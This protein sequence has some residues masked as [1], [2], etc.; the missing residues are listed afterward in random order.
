M[1]KLY[2]ELAGVY[3]EMY[4][5]IFDYEKE[6]GLYDRILRR[7]HCRSVLEVGCGGGRLAPFFLDAGYRYQGIDVSA[8]MLRIA[9]RE[10]PSAKFV[11]ADMRNF[12]IPRLVDAVAVTGRTF[13]HLVANPDILAALTSFRRALKNGGLLVFDCF[14]ADEMIRRIGKRSTQSIRRADTVFRRLNRTSLNLKTGWTFNWDANYRIKKKGREERIVKDRM[15][16]RA[17]TEEELSL[18]LSLSG[19]EFLDV[20]KGSVY[21]FS[22]RKT[23]SRPR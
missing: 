19:F 2:S 18:F 13:S 11:R 7:H 15:V 17:F 12:S 3:H 20:I 22:A 5:S 1:P 16:L 23:A 8:D 9:R 6:F 4:G 10:H 21:T 14:R